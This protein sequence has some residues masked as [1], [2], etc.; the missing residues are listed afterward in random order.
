MIDVKVTNSKLLERGLTIVEEFANCNRQRAK[1]C[2]LKAIYKLDDVP[3]NISNQ[4]RF[5]HPKINIVI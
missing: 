4:V 2:V 5:E 3:E 1:E